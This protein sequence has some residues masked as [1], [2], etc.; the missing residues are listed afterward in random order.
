MYRLPPSRARPWVR[1]LPLAWLACLGCTNAPASAQDTEQVARRLSSIVATCAASTGQVEVL[2]AGQSF[3]ERI[4]EGATFRPGD[5]VRTGALASARIE[6]LEGGRIELEEQSVA[7]VERAPEGD[8]GAHPSPLVALESGSARGF[9]PASANG[10]VHALLVRTSDGAIVAVS[11]GEAGQPAEFRLSRTPRGAVLSVARGRL[12]LVS[13]QR[14]QALL[15]G[16]GVELGRG[17][18]APVFPLPV[19]PTSLEPGIDARFT[20]AAGLRVALAWSEV[21]GADH[22][23]VQIARDL[24]FE[25]L[26]V[27]TP[28]ARAPFT[29]TPDGPGTYVWRVATADADGRQSEY[30]FARRIYVD[31]EVNRDLLVTPSDG[32]ERPFSATRGIVFAWQTTG[33]RQRFRFVVARDPALQQVVRV[34]RTGMQQLS[35]MRL[36]PGTYYW[37]AYVDSTPAEP[38]FQ[39]ARKLVVLPPVAKKARLKTPRVVDTWGH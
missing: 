10:D 27:S 18:V 21:V 36:R 24:G 35:L 5:W 39:K 15:E 29:F 22:Y 30:G 32:H 13:G 34:Q 12:T 17:L 26:V 9:L 3:W 31:A 2:R 37:G 25:Q 16:H 20:W 8:A 11:P 4:E 6:F 23:R 33:G 38:L 7:L 28:S 19:F 14:Q 1:A